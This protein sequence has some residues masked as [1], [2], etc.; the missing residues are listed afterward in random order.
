MKKY[1]ARIISAAALTA[2]AV[3]A[4]LLP[5][6]STSARELSWVHAVT[7]SGEYDTC[8]FTA[9][10]EVFRFPNSRVTVRFRHDFSLDRR[11]ASA[12][13][14]WNGETGGT[15]YRVDANGGV[16]VAENV[17]QALISDDGRRI[18][19]IQQSDGGGSLYLY[20]HR[21][22]KTTLLDN[23]VRTDNRVT[24]FALSPDGKTVAYCRADGEGTDFTGMVWSG[25]KY[26]EL[27]RNRSPIA[28][29]D[30]M[31]HLYYIV[32]ENPDKPFD[33]SYDYYVK[34][35]SRETV[36]ANRYPY[37]G[38]V[39]NRD[40]TEASPQHMGFRLFSTAHGEAVEVSYDFLELAGPYK[41]AGQ[42]LQNQH[43]YTLLSYIRLDIES[44]AG[45]MIRAQYDERYHIGR[46]NEDYSFSPIISPYGNQPYQ[47]SDDGR[48]ALALTMPFIYASD[49]N[50]ENGKIA[51]KNAQSFVASPDL[52]KV[53]YITLEDALYYCDLAA[54]GEAILIA[55]NAELCQPYYIHYGFSPFALSQVGGRVYFTT[56]RGSTLNC[57]GPDGVV[58]ELLSFEVG[59]IRL[60][61][62]GDAFL[63]THIRENVINCDYYLLRS[64]GEPA[65]LTTGPLRDWHSAMS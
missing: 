47:V 4:A 19:Y 11:Y 37:G 45:Q 2:I 14:D 34:C 57:I 27:G 49:G 46:I 7:D 35:G 44:F 62:I 61:L 41:S 20:D 18:A 26:H 24:R 40:F 9:D 33:C 38:L 43:Y 32:P 56:N 13:G 16:F 53:W 15:L 10:G 48:S 64:G 51:V 1:F 36:L 6:M 55:E 28:V 50:D 52:S 42:E 21:R 25:G 31:S 39:F 3:L 59:R 58:R 30:G 5:G 60:E 54:N 17:L 23:S 12:I 65:Y 29:A 22:G 8:F 63:I